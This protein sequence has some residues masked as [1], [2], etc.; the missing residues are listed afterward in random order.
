MGSLGF[1]E[2]NM[3]P[4]GLCNSPATFQRLIERCIGDLNLRFCLIYLDDIII[5]SSTF[6]EHLERL[7]AVFEILEQHNLKLKASR[8]EFFKT[9]VS[10]L[11]HVVSKAGVET[12]S[13][14][15][16]SLKSW[17]IPKNVKDVRAFLGFTGYY[18]RFIKNYASIARPLNDL[19]V[20]HCTNDT[21][22]GK[23]S[24]GKSAPFVWV[25]R[26]QTA[27]DSLIEK[28]TSPAILAYADYR[29]PFK[30]HADA[31]CSGLGAILYQ[32]HDGVDRVISYASRSLKPS[33]RNYPAHKPEFRA[34]KW[35]VTEKF[36]D[37]L[38]GTEFEVVTD[39]NPLTYVFTTA[40]LDATGQR[41]LAELSNYNCSISYRS[42]KQDADGLSRMYDTD[43]VST[44]F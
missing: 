3:I 24:K 6:E 44:I 34:L 14:K 17:L 15:I 32:N 13:E 23:K 40:K 8:C 20:G 19:L 36:H 7:E 39:N 27:F 38:H 42:G 31:C 11:G 18:R 12:E 28:L 10:Y 35:A 25:E 16:E 5:Y 41:W 33:E 1:Y 30:L 2:F 43:T 29:L 9:K 4:F 21:K 37:Y 26:K 22:K